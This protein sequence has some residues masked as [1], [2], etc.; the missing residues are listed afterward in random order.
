MKLDRQ[1]Y[2][3]NYFFQC[4]E[5]AGKSIAVFLFWVVVEMIRARQRRMSEKMNEIVVCKASDQST[6]ESVA[7]A[8]HGLRTVYELVQMANIMLLKLQSVFISKTHK[9]IVQ[10]SAFV[11]TNILSGQYYSFA[12]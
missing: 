2:L 6:M 4:R 5:W 8:Q 12:S 3:M 11:S 1:W 9:V 10:K 7:S